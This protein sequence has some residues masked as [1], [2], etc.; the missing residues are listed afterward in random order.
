MAVRGHA[1]WRKGP[2]VESSEKRSA[3]K[4]LKCPMNNLW[5]SQQREGGREREREMEREGERESV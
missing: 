3:L 1:R 4:G 2:G 5:A